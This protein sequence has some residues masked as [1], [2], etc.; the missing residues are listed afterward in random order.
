MS[1]ANLT[2]RGR[3]TI[4]KEIRD[5]MGLRAGDK[6]VFVEN[7]GSFIL[8]KSVANSPFDP[9]VGFLENPTGETVDEI[10]EDLRGR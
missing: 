5:R 7:S 9:W 3:I 8:K 4:P 6:V 1:T 2:T 10:I